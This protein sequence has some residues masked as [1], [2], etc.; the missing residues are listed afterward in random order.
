M[1]MVDDISSNYCPM[2]DP[3]SPLPRPSVSK[4]ACPNIMVSDINEMRSEYFVN[5]GLLSFSFDVH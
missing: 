5:E 1:Q 2:F 3:T 4:Q